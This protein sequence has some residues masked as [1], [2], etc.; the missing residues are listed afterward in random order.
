MDL[1]RN[2]VSQLIISVLAIMA[3]IVVIK[4]TANNYLPDSGIGGAT[5]QIINIV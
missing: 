5:K 2:P 4:L 3:V 1:L